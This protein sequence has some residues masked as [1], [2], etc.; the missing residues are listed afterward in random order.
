MSPARFHYNVPG[1]L[2]NGR[3]PVSAQAWPLHRRAY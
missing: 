3:H 1:Y 2:A